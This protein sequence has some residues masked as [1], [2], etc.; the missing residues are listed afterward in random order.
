MIAGIFP[1][2]GIQH[3]TMFDSFDQTQVKQFLQYSSDILNKNVFNILE[4]SPDELA[5]P[6]NAQIITTIFS[7]FLTD[8]WKKKGGPD[9]NYVAGHS[10]GEYAACHYAGAFT[11]ED[12]LSTVQ[13]RAQSMETAM[14]ADSGYMLGIYNESLLK[15]QELL[16]EHND[17]NLIIASYNTPT[18]H[19]VSGQTNALDKFYGFLSNKNIKCYKLAVSLPCHTPYLFKSGQEIADVLKNKIKLEKMKV[20]IVGC[21]DGQ[22]KILKHDVVESLSNQ[23][24][25][26]ILWTTVLKKLVTNKVS[27]FILFAP[28]TT[29]SFRRISFRRNINANFPDLPTLNIH[30]DRT[31][32]YSIEALHASNTNYITQV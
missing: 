9:F 15:T 18:F 21:F 2:Q 14:G 22:E 1:G 19:V 25:M 8:Q 13:S 16:I 31:L 32:N 17:K 29:A 4:L 10:V 3:K 5:R 30:N 7:A 24:Y 26:P 6:Q 23:I 12:L 27:A 11:Y 20:P 28:V